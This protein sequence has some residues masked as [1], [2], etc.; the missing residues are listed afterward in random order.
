MAGITQAEDIILEKL[1]T[2]FG[3]S[4]RSV[5]S[6]SGPWTVESLR[7]AISMSPCV[8]LAFLGGKKN[9]N[10]PEFIDAKFGIYCVARSTSD[11]QRRQGA[12]RS[13]D[14]YNM[15]QV[16]CPVL[17]MSVLSGIGTLF[18]EAVST[19]F[20]EQTFK[21]GATVY[22]AVFNLPNFPLPDAFDPATL[23]DFITFHADSDMAPADGDIDITS[24]E[25]L[26]Q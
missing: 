4:V 9:E 2:A 5:E 19:V 18:L 23:A 3:N 20:A 26:P 14:A 1:T 6:L 22:S 10:G 13:V 24:E 12:S 16:I 21:L 8:R 11:L 7:R 17:N 25:T 15:I